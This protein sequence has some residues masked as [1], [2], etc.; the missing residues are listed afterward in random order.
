MLRLI[1][2]SNRVEQTSVDDNLPPVV[3]LS[4]SQITISE[5]D[6]TAIP[7]VGQDALQRTNPFLFNLLRVKSTVTTTETITSTS[8]TVVTSDTKTFTIVGCTP[9]DFSEF[10]CPLISSFAPK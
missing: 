8:T 1:R 10:S 9:A 3:E 4:S 5:I 7:D 2:I 6:A